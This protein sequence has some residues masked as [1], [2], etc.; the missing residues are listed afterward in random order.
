M[1]KGEAKEKGKDTK[2]NNDDTLSPFAPTQKSQNTHKTPPLLLNRYTV[3]YNKRV[4]G[5]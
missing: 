2:K 5:C 3:K 1:G 4:E